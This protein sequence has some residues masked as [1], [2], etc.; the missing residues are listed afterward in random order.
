MLCRHGDMAVA[1]PAGAV[2]ASGGIARG[3]RGQTQHGGERSQ[4]CLPAEL[5]DHVMPRRRANPAG[6]G[7][8]VVQLGLVDELC[9]TVAPVLVG[10]R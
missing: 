3:R 1:A 7:G 8:I 6:A 9:L 4:A 10:G 2:S 5:V